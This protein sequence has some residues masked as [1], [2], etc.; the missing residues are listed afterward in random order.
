MKTGGIRVD[1]LS[2]DTRELF[3]HKLTGKAG[4]LSLKATGKV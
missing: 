1:L 3:L 2:K 4:P